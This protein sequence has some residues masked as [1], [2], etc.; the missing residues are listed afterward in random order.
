[1]NLKT[2]QQKLSKIK[3]KEEIK[4][5]QMKRFSMHCKTIKG[6]YKWIIW[7]FGMRVEAENIFKEMFGG[8]TSKF[9]ENC[10]LR[11]KKL[12]RTQ[13]HKIWIQLQHVIPQMLKSNEII[14]IAEGDTSHTKEQRYGWEEM[15]CWRQY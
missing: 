3:Q 7:L 15:S 4:F 11:C 10:K 5:K 9:V 6:P 13:W 8:K 12:H 2:Y 1:M 14:K